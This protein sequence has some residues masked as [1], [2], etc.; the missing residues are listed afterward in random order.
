MRLLLQTSRHFMLARQCVFR[1]CVVARLVASCCALVPPVPAG[2]AQFLGAGHARAA[3]FLSAGSRS[4][5]VQPGGTGQVRPERER[6]REDALL[7]TVALSKEAFAKWNTGRARY[8]QRKNKTYV[9][10][11]AAGASDPA[12][13]PRVEAA[14]AS[15]GFE[16]LTREAVLAYDPAQFQ[17]AEAVLEMIAGAEPRVHSTGLSALHLAFDASWDRGKSFKPHRRKVNGQLYLSE[18]GALLRREFERF[19][20]DF[21]GPHMQAHIPDCRQLF[22]ERTP[23][24]RMQ[25]PS[26]ARVGYP[27][28][29]S[30]YFHQRGQINFW[31]PI[32]PVF[33]TN[34]LWV[35]SRPGRH[36]Y[37]ALELGLGECVRFY[38]N[39]CMHF[40]VPNDTP[41]TR[42]SLDLRVVPGPC[43][44]DD[45]PE[46]RSAD[47]QA[48]F[49]VGGYYAVAQFDE[50][51]S[52]WSLA[53]TVPDPARA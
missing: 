46:G 39:Q 50:T 35:E 4:Y 28:S 34:T 19:V 33:G 6:E 30:M 5:C 27:H 23:S 42:V 44:E 10:R 21:I 45:P 25:P 48:M 7:E 36:D 17:L 51:A 24:V 32:T 14:L 29:D 26:I 20:C 53:E 37:H 43:F 2:R 15:T 11:R 9:E 12:R 31:V 13:D 41:H 22:F 18:H 49:R 1:L 8:S 16:A 38:G 3:C 52:T 40:T 47:G